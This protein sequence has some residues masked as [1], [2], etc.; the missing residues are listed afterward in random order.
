MNKKLMDK[1]KQNRTRPAEYEGE[2]ILIKIYSG[3]EWKE[4]AKKLA[5]MDETQTAKFISEQILDENHEPC[6]DAEYILS[7]DCT[8]AALMELITIIRDVNNGM[9]L[10]N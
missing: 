1:I 8:N 6:F 9:Y 2:P 4:I 7:E 3:K 10:K 5:K